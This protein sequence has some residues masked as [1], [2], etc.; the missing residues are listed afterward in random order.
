MDDDDPED[1]PCSRQVVSNVNRN[2][3]L[4]PAPCSVICSSSC[5]NMNSNSTYTQYR[6]FK[7]NVREPLEWPKQTDICCWWCCHP[8]KTTPVCIPAYHCSVSKHFE[9]F[10]V[11]CSCNCAKAS[12]QQNYSSESAEQLMWMLIMAKNVFGTD[13]GQFHAA[14][15]RIFLKMF[16]GFGKFGLAGNSRSLG[17][18]YRSGVDKAGNVR[19]PLHEDA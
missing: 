7:S 9:V 15:P 17:I 8:F 2:V 12:I 5:K 19:H 11:F 1:L 10:G 14:P 4:P 6:L 16:G 13:L 18:G 3:Y